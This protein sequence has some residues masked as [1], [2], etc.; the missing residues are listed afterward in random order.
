MNLV[1][2]SSED[3]SEINLVE[4]LARNRVLFHALSLCITVDVVVHK[5]SM[6][7][8]I[9]SDRRAALGLTWSFKFAIC[10]L[11]SLFYHPYELYGS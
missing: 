8:L 3:G 11:F 9:L 5:V 6:N 2:H 7:I 4:S 1:F 10:V